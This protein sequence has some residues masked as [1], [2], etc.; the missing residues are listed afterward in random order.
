MSDYD[1]SLAD[2]P[3]DLHKFTKPRGMLVMCVV[4]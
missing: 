4:P 1:M 3:Q 2:E